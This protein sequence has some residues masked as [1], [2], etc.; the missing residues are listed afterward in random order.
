MFA[1]EKKRNPRN[2]AMMLDLLHIVVGILVVVCA[3]LAFVNPEK[4]QI[5]FPVIFGLAALLNGVNGYH[6][7]AESGRDKK[8]KIGA[9]ALCVIAG[10]LLAVGII[11]GV[12]IWRQP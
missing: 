2:D 8:K 1:Q 3:V 5:L 9:A 10:L 4:N 6:R 12:S 7:L 11:S